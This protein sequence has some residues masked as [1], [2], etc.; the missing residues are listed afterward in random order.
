[1]LY[2]HLLVTSENNTLQYEKQRIYEEGKAQ[3]PQNGYRCGTIAC[4]E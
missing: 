4:E 1:M 3:K 2:M